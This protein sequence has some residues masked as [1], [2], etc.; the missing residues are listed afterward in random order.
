MLYKNIRSEGEKSDFV[1]TI[2]SSYNEKFYLGATI[3][4]PGIEYYELSNYTEN[5][6]EDTISNLASFS[7]TEEL[8]VSGKGINI[9]GGA[10]LR[11]SEN[12]KLGASLHSP[13]YYRIEETYMSSMS[14]YF[15]IDNFT[16]NSPYNYFEYEII[17]PW[18]AMLSASTTLHKM[19]LISA[20]Y[21]VV[22]YA[23]TRMNANTY[24]FR[25]ENESINNIFTQTN[26]IR[27][28][29]EINLHPLIL[30]GGYSHYGSAY[31]NQDA[32]KENYSFGIGINSGIF[33]LDVAYILT[34]GEDEYK[35]Y[36]DDYINPID[37]VNTNHNVIL[38]LGLRY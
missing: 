22:D 13:T 21:E 15:N 7:Y 6:L 9:K 25:E 27:L 24:D 10:I 23:F 1:F 8:S 5:M 31:L 38:T 37:L 20:D 36:S 30:R 35:L 12:F 14:T 33:F 2:G 32:S 29:T 28:G 4:F 17:T 3:G 16:E 18:K 19:I 26:N 34:Q 11:L